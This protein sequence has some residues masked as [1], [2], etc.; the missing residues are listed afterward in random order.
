MQ[1]PPFGSRNQSDLQRIYLYTSIYLL[2]ISHSAARVDRFFWGA[3][4]PTVSHVKGWFT[5]SFPLPKTRGDKS[6]GAAW[7]GMVMQTS[8]E[9]RSHMGSRGGVVCKIQPS[10]Y[11]YSKFFM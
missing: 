7:I 10:R 6:P 4:N 2:G 9:V 8:Q 5:L 11:F 3:P 1:N